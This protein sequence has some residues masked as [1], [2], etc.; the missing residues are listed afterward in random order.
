VKERDLPNNGKYITFGLWGVLKNPLVTGLTT[1]LF[2]IL[3]RHWTADTL[4]LC[5]NGTIFY[6]RTLQLGRGKFPPCFRGWPF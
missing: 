2:W 5:C 3:R 1:M 4:S 6:T